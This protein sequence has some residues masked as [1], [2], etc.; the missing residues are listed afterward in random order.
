VTTLSKI[1]FSIDTVKILSI[2]K[3]VRTVSSKAITYTDEFKIHF[4]EEYYSGK[5]AR[6]IFGE[7]GLDVE[8]L[9]GIKRI[10]AASYRWRI[11]YKKHA[12]WG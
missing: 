3:W 2:N 10:E 5:S 1:L 8:L 11:A 12:I 9:G 6:Q 7:A 4:I